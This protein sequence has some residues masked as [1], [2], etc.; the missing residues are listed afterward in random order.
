MSR[1]K[2]IDPKLKILSEKLEAKLTI[3][4]DWDPKYPKHNDTDSRRSAISQYW[5]EY[6]D[7]VSLLMARY[8]DRMFLMETSDLN[9]QDRVESLLKWLGITVPNVEVVWANKGDKSRI[10]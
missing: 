7:R 5:E 6:Y 4:R 3:D 10:L 9:D 8:P 2:E 1:F